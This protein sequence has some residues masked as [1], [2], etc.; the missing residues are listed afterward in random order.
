MK[1]R[2]HH[3]GFSLVELVLVVVI[4]GILGAIAV[5]RLSGL[6]SDADEVA[7]AQNLAILTRAVEV[8]KAEHNGSPPTS[9]LQLVRYTDEAG[10]TSP[11]PAP[12]YLF[13]PYLR[14]IPSLPVGSN[15]GKTGL[16]SGGSPGDTATAGWWIDSGTGDVR[17]NA[18]DSDLLSDG[19]KLNEAVSTDFLKK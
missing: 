1:V 9:A 15:K 8:Y 19:T 2:H 10:N 16:V 4:M 7:L 5:P 6:G 13:G 12:P 14:K 17:A 18:P 3:R 11:A